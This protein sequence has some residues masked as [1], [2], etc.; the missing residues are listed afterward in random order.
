MVVRKLDSGTMRWLEESGD[1]LQGMIAA[2]T[3]K[4][5]GATAGSWQ[6]KVSKESKSRAVCY[7]YSNYDNAVFEEFGTGKYTTKGHYP[8]F[9]GKIPWVYKGKDGKFYRTSG[10]RARHP[11]TDAMKHSLPIIKEMGKGILK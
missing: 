5:T 11:A 9:K 3:K 10:K 7:V 4:D 6:H 8:A 1:F 2:Y